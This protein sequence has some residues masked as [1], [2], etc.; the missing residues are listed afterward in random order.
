MVMAADWS[1]RGDE[2]LFKTNAPLELAESLYVR[3]NIFTDA[4]LLKRLPVLP[5]SCLESSRIL[6]QKR[7]L[8]ERD[9]IFP[10]S[11]IDYVARLLQKENDEFMNRKLADLPAD[12]RLLETRRIMHKDLHRH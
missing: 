2:T 10:A 6:L 4:E 9:G 12:D 7:D 8:Y 3:G 5:T 1:F 11:V